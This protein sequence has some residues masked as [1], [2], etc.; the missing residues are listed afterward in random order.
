ML[1]TI[2]LYGVLGKQFGREHKLAVNSA[3]EAIRA[4]GVVI[5]GFKKFLLRSREDGL[6]FAVFRGKTNVTRDELPF[7]A[8]QDVIRIAPVLSGSKQAGLFQTILGA[9]LIAASYFIP[10]LGP[11][12]SMALLSSGVGMALGGVVQMLSPQMGGLSSTSADDG[13]SYYFNGAVNS[14]AQGNPVPLIYGETW[15]GSQVVS[16]GIYAEDQT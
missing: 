4:L 11:T 5:P 2:R 15:C 16:S 1:R 10:G 9:V 3:G 12:V 6:T 7:P 8:G 13:Q 14:T